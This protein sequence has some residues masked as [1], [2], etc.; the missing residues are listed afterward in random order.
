MSANKLWSG[1]ALAIAIAMTSCGKSNKEAQPQEEEVS[2]CESTA[3]C[4]ESMVCLDG[5]CA[6][7][8]G[9]AIYTDTKNAITPDKVRKEIEAIGDKRQQR[10]D[11]LLDQ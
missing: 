9:G 8:K 11:E 6:S 7:T 4:G 3:D 1:S 2:S 5:E 10:Y